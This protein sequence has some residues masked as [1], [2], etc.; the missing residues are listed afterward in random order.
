MKL[1]KPSFQEAFVAELGR[2][3]TSD[4]CV[5]LEASSI[6]TGN[7]KAQEWGQALA[8][9]LISYEPSLKE[10][11]AFVTLQPAPYGQVI[12]EIKN[13]YRKI[14]QFSLRIVQKAHYVKQLNWALSQ[15]LIIDPREP[16]QFTEAGQQI[17]SE[18]LPLV[19][20]GKTDWADY[21]P[22]TVQKWKREVFTVF[23]TALTDKIAEKSF[24]DKV[25][26]QTD[27]YW[28]AKKPRADALVVVPANRT[29]RLRMGEEYLT[30]FTIE[31]A[32][33]IM[34]S[35][36]DTYLEITLNNQMTLRGFIE[37]YT[38]KNGVGIKISWYL[39]G[40]AE[41]LLLL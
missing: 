5:V 16:N 37:D 36:G 32:P 39:Y 26:G 6:P 22:E 3:L 40:K 17:L 35:N 9:G 33:E 28:V 10:E 41:N 7:E 18:W 24:L 19:K 13:N 14:H 4:G 29:G 20:E 31:K 25:L 15:S 1:Q 34:V 23:T 8:K 30:A 11:H 2:A 38:D 27:T 12:V 21:N